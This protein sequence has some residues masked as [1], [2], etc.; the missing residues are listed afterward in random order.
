MKEAEI[1]AAWHGL[2]S[3]S[4]CQIQDLVLFADLT[5]EDFGAIHLPIDD[6]WLPPGAVLYRAET[7]QTS[8][9]T[10]REG[11]VKLEQYLP[12][13][14]RRIVSLAGA[15]DVIGLEAM[16]GTPYEHDAV[17]LQP[18]KLCRIPTAVI[19][20]LSPKLNQALMR[21]WHDSVRTAHACL[22][23]LSTGAARQRV[24]RLF[25]HLA[26]PEIQRC[27]LFG[28]ED[29]GALLGVTT[30]TA[31]KTVAEFKRQGVIREI[32]PNLF[33]RDIDALNRIADGD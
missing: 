16:L 5:P 8:L 3:C 26:P 7:T 10:L 11:L 2:A 21:K 17:A 28:R 14:A 33:E 22:R 13:G 29:V 20:R 4:R 31:S 15:G 30:E 12:D 18:S 32:A 9:F 25:L 23:D 24:A 6:L 27:R 19:Q 1:E